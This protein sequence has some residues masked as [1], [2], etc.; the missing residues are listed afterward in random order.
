MVV[1]RRKVVGA[2]TSLVNVR[3]MQLECVRVLH[4]ALLVSALLDWKGDNYMED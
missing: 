1:S 2:I 3:G 4:N